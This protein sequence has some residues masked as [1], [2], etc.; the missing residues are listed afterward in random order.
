M[1]I[2]I[3]GYSLGGHGGMETVCKRLVK[4]IAENQPE[5]QVKFLF[6]NEKKDVNEEWYAGLD[7]GTCSSSIHNTKLRRLHFAY[8]LSRFLCGKKTDLIIAL[9]TLSCYIAN[10]ARKWIFGKYPIASW[11]HFSLYDLYKYN[12]ILYADAHLVISNGINRQVQELGVDENDVYTIFNP[13]GR[14]E[15]NI[16]VSSGVPVNFIYIGR[17]IFEGQKRLKDLLTSLAEVQGD[18]RLHVVGDGDDME[19]CRQYSATLGIGIRV[20]WHGWQKKP[21][22]YVSDH[23][24]NLK[25]LVLTSAFEGLPMTLLEAMAHGIFCVSSDCP[26]GPADVIDGHNGRLYKVG[27]SPQLTAILQELVD[28]DIVIDQQQIKGSISKFY[29]DNYYHSFNQAIAHILVRYGNK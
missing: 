22:G 15:T 5:T 16:A 26:T 23:I 27:D 25:A 3:V 21:W 20:I 28:G 29:D 8:S 19:L 7:A 11:L 18:W 12:Y 24:G 10:V 1:N 17:V 9:D 13:V 6:F 14:T 4:L 2:V